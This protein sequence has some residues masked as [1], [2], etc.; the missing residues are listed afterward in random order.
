MKD[1]VKLAYLFDK[2]GNYILADKLDKIARNNGRVILADQGVYNPVFQGVNLKDELTKLVRESTKLE[3]GKNVIDI[4]LLK[5]KIQS[6]VLRY[7]IYDVKFTDGNVQGLFNNNTKTLFVS[8]NEDIYKTVQNFNS[9][10]RHELIH[11][12]SPL[13]ARGQ[14]AKQQL[15][16]RRN[17][18]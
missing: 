14:E 10:F 8:P 15:D 1:I 18:L 5:Q 16:I 7:F 2:T 9:T 11:G 17:N 6:G 4:P 3:N 12:T 13:K